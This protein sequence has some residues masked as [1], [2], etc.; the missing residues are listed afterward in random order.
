MSDYEHILL[1]D[2]CCELNIFM[3]C[4]LIDQLVKTLSVGSVYIFRVVM[5]LPF[6]TIYIRAGGVAQW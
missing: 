2:L 3:I 5:I 4:S 1:R 6:E